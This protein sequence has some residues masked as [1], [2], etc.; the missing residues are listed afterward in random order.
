MA[1][2]PRC[3]QE[4]SYRGFE[5]KKIAKVEYWKCLICDKFFEKKIKK[6]KSVDEI[7]NKKKN[8]IIRKNK[9]IQKK[10]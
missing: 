6:H 2:C 10:L 7:I 9:K 4:A 5:R 8:G 3:D 1:K